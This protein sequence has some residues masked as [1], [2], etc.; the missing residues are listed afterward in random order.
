MSDKFL[1]QQINIKFCVKLAKNARDTQF[2]QY[3]A[4]SKL[5][6]LQW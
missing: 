6:S 5:Q 3:D 4:E 1:E 2:F